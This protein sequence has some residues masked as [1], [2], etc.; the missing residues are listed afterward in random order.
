[1]KVPSGKNK[2]KETGKAKQKNLNCS[3]KKQE[4]QKMSG[5]W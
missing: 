3:G 2:I 1:M 4:Q 5:K